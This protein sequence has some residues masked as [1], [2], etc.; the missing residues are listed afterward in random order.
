MVERRDQM[1]IISWRPD[2]RER[3]PAFFQQI[4]VDKRA[5]PKPNAP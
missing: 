4:A 3:I 2:E 5:F 1:R